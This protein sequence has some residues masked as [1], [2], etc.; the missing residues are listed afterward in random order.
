MRERQFNSAPMALSC[1]PLRLESSLLDPF[2]KRMKSLGDG[3]GSH[4]SPA[5]TSHLRMLLSTFK[6]ER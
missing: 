2:G 6:N 1:E 5:T 4:S 3:D